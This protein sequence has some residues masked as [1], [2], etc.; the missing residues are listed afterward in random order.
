M[1]RAV[2]L[3]LVVMPA[4]EVG[5]VAGELAVALRG[6]EIPV[7]IGGPLILLEPVLLHLHEILGVLLAIILH[8]NADR[9]ARSARVPAACV[10]SIQPELYQ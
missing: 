1:Q 6:G 3:H 4:E 9:S 5:A 8:D 7:D 2:A 10:R